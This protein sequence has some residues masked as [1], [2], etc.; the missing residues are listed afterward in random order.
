MHFFPPNCKSLICSHSSVTVLSCPRS[1]SSSTAEHTAV[2]GNT[3]F[4]K[5]K[6][7]ILPA[8]R[9][10]PSTTQL[11]AARWLGLHSCKSVRP[12]LLHC[13]HCRGCC[14][15]KQGTAQTKAHRHSVLF[16]CLLRCLLSAFAFA[17]RPQRRARQLALATI[18]LLL[19]LLLL[20]HQ[21]Q[22]QHCH[23]YHQL[24]QFSLFRNYRQ[25]GISGNKFCKS[26]FN[27]Q[28]QLGSRFLCV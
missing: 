12:L 14:C 20:P 13:H 1:C 4:A 2:K 11:E 21:Q 6:Q 16:Y 24:Q 17:V 9:T 27:F 19:S 26:L 5:K 3:H 8:S 7:A 25:L 23:H 18:N 10:T 28:C 22:Q 15:T